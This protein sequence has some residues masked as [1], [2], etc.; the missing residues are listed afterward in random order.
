[1]DLWRRGRI[2][3]A[4]VSSHSADFCAISSGKVGRTV[5]GFGAMAG[6]KALATVAAQQSHECVIPANGAGLL[7]KILSGAELS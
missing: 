5:T 2:F 1:M 3:V 4:T 7:C 6:V